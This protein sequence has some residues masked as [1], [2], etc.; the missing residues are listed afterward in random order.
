MRWRDLVASAAR[1]DFSMR[2]STRQILALAI[3]VVALGVGIRLEIAREE[4]LLPM[5]LTPLDP[6]RPEVDVHTM[7]RLPTAAFRTSGQRLVDAGTVS[8]ARR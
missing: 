7:R 5:P 3:V 6:A 4:K 8:G 2:K 1:V